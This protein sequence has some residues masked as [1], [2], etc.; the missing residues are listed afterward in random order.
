MRRD[1][2][3]VRG[4]RSLLTRCGVGRVTLT[5][6]EDHLWAAA[7]RRAPVAFRWFGRSLTVADLDA[8]LGD[9]GQ[10][11]KA[12]RRYRDGDRVWPFVINPGAMA[13]R[14][15]FVIVRGRRPVTGVVTL[16]S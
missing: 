15:G 8:G 13:M 2:L 7:V 16:C 11:R 1:P 10:W 14:A 6:D 4:V 12:R 5:G 9:F 3:P